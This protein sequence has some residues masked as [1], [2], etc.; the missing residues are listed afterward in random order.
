[1]DNPF[2]SDK[3]IFN[4]DISFLI[5]LRAKPDIIYIIKQKHKDEIENQISIIDKKNDLIIWNAI[6]TKEIGEI[7]ILKKYLHPIYNKFYK[8][9]P[10]LN[11]LKQLQELELKMINTYIDL[12]I[13]DMEVTD[14][15]VMN[16]IL[17]YLHLNIESKMSL[18]KLSNDLN[19]SAGYI[20]TC[21]KKH[22]GM[23]IM[24]YAKKIR[25]D[26]AK[27]L[28]LTSTESILEIGLTLGFH[29]QSHFSK[30]FKEYTNM[31]PSQYRNNNL[32]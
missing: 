21:F 25:I 29:D 3:N 24:S 20:S 10:T 31:T 26:R 9:I 23:T 7:G 11:T 12:I 27:V 8:I 28:L 4:S 17:R 30:V 16:R 5:Q 32:I 1:M 18:K 14:N 6:Y 19:L 2:A 13:N 22:M 15:Y